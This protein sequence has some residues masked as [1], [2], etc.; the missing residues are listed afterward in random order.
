LSKPATSSP[1][2]NGGHCGIA[3]VYDIHDYADEN[4]R[5]MEAVAAKIMGLVKGRPEE[6]NVVALKR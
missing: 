1:P 4:K 6:S 5:I 2:S 3:D